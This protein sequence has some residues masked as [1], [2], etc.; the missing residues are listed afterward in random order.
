MI[1]DV[2]TALKSVI[3]RFGRDG[4]AKIKGETVFLAA[5]HLTA[6]AK[7]L[8]HVDVLTDAAKEIGSV[9]TVVVKKDKFGTRCVNLVSVFL[10]D[11]PA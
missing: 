10:F 5:K 9:N 2:V 11:C 6:I 3:T 7:S 1:T 4:I 8:A